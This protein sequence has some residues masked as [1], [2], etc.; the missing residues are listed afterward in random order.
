MNQYRAIDRLIL[1]GWDGLLS[2]AP[3]PFVHPPQKLGEHVG[4]VDRA[5]DMASF[6]AIAAYA[7]LF[8]L[9]VVFGLGG[10]LMLSKDVAAGLG[11]L[12]VAACPAAI[13]V[14]LLWARR[15]HR[16]LC[17]LLICD[18]AGRQLS[19]AVIDNKGRTLSRVSDAIEKCSVKS[20]PVSLYSKA[21]SLDGERNTGSGVYVG[22]GFALLVWVQGS[23]FAIGAVKSEWELAEI[24][25]PDWFDGAERSAGPPLEFASDR[26]LTRSRVGLCPSC[27]YDRR[28]LSPEAV[29]P[30]CGSP[31]VG[32]IRN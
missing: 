17:R 10:L 15:R 7:G 25:I 28:G 14:L 13:G 27:D 21:S 1:A 26:R 3:F 18:R 8:P 9:S 2:F 19:I 5:S 4:Y 16:S 11:S 29:C 22:K 20:H 23:C 32:P 30:E 31:S 12:G 24:P 6:G